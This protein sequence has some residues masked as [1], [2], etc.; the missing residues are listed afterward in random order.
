M[1][2]HTRPAGPEAGNVISRPVVFGWKL[3]G[4]LDNFPWPIPWDDWYIYRIYR[5]MKTIEKI[6]HS[7]F[8]YMKTI[9]KINHI[10]YIYRNMK[11][12][13]KINH[14]IFTVTWKPLKKSTTVYLS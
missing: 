6:N 7:I 4:F 1:V 2:H 10:W 12:I 11:T 5:N 3:Q 13:E 8:T 14:S 9:E